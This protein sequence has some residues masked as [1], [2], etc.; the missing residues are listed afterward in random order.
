MRRVCYYDPKK[1]GWV[2]RTIAT[3]KEY[4]IGAIVLIITAIIVYAVSVRVI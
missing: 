3:R 1:C 4:M 2:V